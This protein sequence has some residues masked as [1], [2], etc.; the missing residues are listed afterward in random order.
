MV[1]CSRSVCHLL[2]PYP[3]SATISATSSPLLRTETATCSSV[4]TAGCSRVVAVDGSLAHT[5]WELQTGRLL[6]SECRADTRRRTMPS[7]PGSSS[8]DPPLQIEAAR[9]PNIISLY[10]AIQ[11]GDPG[12]V[13]LYISG[14]VAEI[15]ALEA[16]VGSS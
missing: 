8:D 6:P 5:A 12:Q 9:Y 2:V 4:G 1:A 15:A 11:S 16:E 13:R 3:L 10:A 14:A 7:D